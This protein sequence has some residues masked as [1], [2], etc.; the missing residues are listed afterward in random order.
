MNHY[1]IDSY[2][3]VSNIKLIK[4]KVL[5]STFSIFDKLIH[6]LKKTKILLRF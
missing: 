2:I 3:K 1:L 4:A 6:L 5:A